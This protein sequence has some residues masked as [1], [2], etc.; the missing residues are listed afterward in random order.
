MNVSAHNYTQPDL[1]KAAH[2][3]EVPVK[4]IVEIHVDLQQMG[5]GGDTSWGAYTHDQYRLLG[6]EYAYG[7]TLKPVY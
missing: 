6:D 2:T 4:D 1:E 5:V 7:F 3:N